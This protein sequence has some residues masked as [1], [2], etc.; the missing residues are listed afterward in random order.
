MSADTPASRVVVSLV[1]IGNEVL[2]GKV[3]EL[4]ARFLIGRLRDL[5][6]RL[7][8]VAFVEDETSAIAEAVARVSAR[9][10]LVITSGGVGPTHDDVTVS[11]VAQALGVPVVEDPQMLALIGRHLAAAPGAKRLAR[12]P[13][14][15]VLM[16]GKRIPW[17]VIRCHNVW[18]FPG[19]PMML[20]ALF[21][22]LSEHFGGSPTRYTNKLQLIVEESLICETLDALVSRHPEVEV[23]SYPRREDGVWRLELTFDGPNEAA[24]DAA[25]GEAAD[26]F[27]TW[28]A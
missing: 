20:Q 5:G 2:S 12:V 1:V 10:D 19:V 15:S 7:R 17:P 23:G 28:L 8:E 9:S 27:S 11:G 16:R 24:V 26:L 6:A 25:R 14:G 21:D 22:D 18:L 4:N 3:D 13:E